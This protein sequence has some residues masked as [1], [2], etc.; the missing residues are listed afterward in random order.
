MLLAVFSVTEQDFILLLVP[1]ELQVRLNKSTSTLQS[2]AFGQ[3]LVYVESSSSI[4]T[5]P[6]SITLSV[7]SMTIL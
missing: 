5:L 6:P 2:S 1:F 4:F 7:S 3:A